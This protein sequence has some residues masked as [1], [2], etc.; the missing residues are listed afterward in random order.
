[1]LW[2]VYI[3]SIFIFISTQSELIINRNIGEGN[4]HQIIQ[5][6]QI[7]CNFDANTIFFYIEENVTATFIDGILFKLY[8][9]PMCLSTPIILVRYSVKFFCFFIIDFF[10]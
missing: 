5:L 10:N 4:S 1:M 2:K 8:T 6:T 7:I 9:N 3:I